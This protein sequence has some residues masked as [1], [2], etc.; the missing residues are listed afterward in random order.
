MQRQFHP[1]EGGEGKVSGQYLISLLEL[2]KQHISA[3]D[4]AEAIKLLTQAQ[5]YPPNLG[6]GK[7]FGAQENDI[8]YYLGLCYEA[9][10]NHLA[11]KKY[12]EKAVE[13]TNQLSAVMFYNDQQPDKL[14]YKGLALAKLG[15]TAQADELFKSFVSYGKQNIDKDI[16]LDYF[17]VSL[18]DLLVFEDDLNRR[19]NIH[20]HYISGLGYLGLKEYENATNEFKQALKMDNMHFG[21]KIHGS[22]AKTQDTDTSKMNSAR[23]YPARG[24]WNAAHPSQN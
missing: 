15:R 24:T 9:L 10:E 23:N 1:W 6:E 12:F 8:F 21:A 3:S 5:H 13:G 18:P 14:F 20:C 2:A 16:K 7:L 22:Y 19:N 17:A 11:A 4:Y